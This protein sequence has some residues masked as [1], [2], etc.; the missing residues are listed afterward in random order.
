[1]TPLTELTLETAPKALWRE[2][3][4]GY[5]DGGPHDVGAHPG[6]FFPRATLAFGQGPVEQPLTAEDRGGGALASA[7]IRV[8]CLPRRET[9]TAN[10]NVLDGLG[11]LATDYV[12]FQFQIRAQRPRGPDAQLLAD[13]V[14][15]LLKAL[16]TNPATR[17]ALAAAGITHLEPLKPLAVTSGEWAVRL[18]S[19]PAQLQY[20]IRFGTDMPTLAVADQSLAFTREAPLV[21]GEY[22]S[23]WPRWSVAM[24]AQSARVVALAGSAETTLALELN[25]SLTGRTLTLPGAADGEVTASV[26]LGNVAL[27][28]GQ[29]VRWKIV[30]G[31]GEV[32]AAAWHV[33]LTM[34]VQ[35]A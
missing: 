18:L 21:I 10:S 19:C 4:G 8:V 25:G 24:R 6:V 3:L 26:D 28:A 2:F 32:E 17:Y 11:L 31:P 16:L 12:T 22:L 34:Q 5:F 13:T 29:G 14:A 27:P 30:A 35:A 23:G 15:Q 1:M 20:P 33:T 7:E 9:V